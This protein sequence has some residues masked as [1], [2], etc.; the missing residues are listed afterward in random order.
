VTTYVLEMR[1]T[2]NWQ[3]IRYR[4][5]TSSAKKAELFRGVPRI[6]FTDSGH[7]IVPH[8]REHSGRREPRNTQLAD[9]VQSHI[10]SI[11]RLFKPRMRPIT[12]NDVLSCFVKEDAPSRRWLEQHLDHADKEFCLIWPLSRAQNGYPTAGAGNALR[13]HRI[14]CEYRHGPAPS[15][16]HQAAHSCGK[17]HL[18]C[19]NPWHL[20][21]KTPAENQLERYQQHG[22]QPSRK[23]T[24]QQ[25]DEIRALKGRERT[26]D[27]AARFQVTEANIRQIQSG[28]TWQINKVSRR[29]FTEAEVTLIR[30]TP[31]RQKKA[32]QWAAEFGVK[33][34]VIDRIR[35]RETYAYFNT[36]EAPV[37]PEHPSQQHSTGE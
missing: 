7:G 5:Y 31:W 3:D 14:M 34:S 20:N 36:A 29:Q 12:M 15:P 1:S 21:W 9:H 13:P 33:R 16:I 18:G 6:D 4:E 10:T 30:N 8:V 26:V 2:A 24:A 32:E 11:G 28:K 25:V 23:L 27:I 37:A 22:L 17:G 35:A 19:V